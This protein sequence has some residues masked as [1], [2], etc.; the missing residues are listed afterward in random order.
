MPQVV[1][2]DER[3]NFAYHSNYHCVYPHTASWWKV[4]VIV[5]YADFLFHL[6][7][8]LFGDRYPKNLT[9]IQETLHFSLQQKRF[10]KRKWHH[11]VGTLRFM[12]SFSNSITCNGCYEWF[13]SFL[14]EIA[15]SLFAVYGRLVLLCSIKKWVYVL[16]PRVNTN[17]CCVHP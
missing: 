6:A 4:F 5:N 16:G 8:Q 17:G 7:V 1:L 14:F 9:A 2:G 11:R 13:T 12:P 10:Q 15:R 3:T